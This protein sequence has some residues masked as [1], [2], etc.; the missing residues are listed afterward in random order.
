MKNISIMILTLFLSCSNTDMKREEIKQE[1]VSV[2]Q[3]AQ[4]IQEDTLHYKVLIFY[5]AACSCCHDHFNHFYKK[6]F[7]NATNNVKFYF[8]SDTDKEFYSNILIFNDYN[9][10]VDKIYCIKDTSFLYSLTN[11]KRIANIIN[12]IF[13]SNIYMETVGLP[14]SVI[15][16]KNNI[17]KLQKCNFTDDTIRFRPLPIHDCKDFNLSKIDF[18]K[19]EDTVINLNF[20]YPF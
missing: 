10:N 11:E 7:D 14:T 3:L 6:A 17:V 20:S 16:N 9:I 1:I 5:G 2:N 4:L 18:T 8:I 19:I 12:N 15:I 13:S